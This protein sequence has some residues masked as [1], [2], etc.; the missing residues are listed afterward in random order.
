M[1]LL[2]LGILKSAQMF[3]K[4]SIFEHQFAFSSYMSLHNT[5]ISILETRGHR[6][7][8]DFHEAPPNRIER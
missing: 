5:V 6:Q 3:P 7:I 1:A 8:V 2:V 4:Y